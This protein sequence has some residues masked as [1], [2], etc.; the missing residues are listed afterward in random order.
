VL[1]IFERSCALSTSCHGNTASPTGSTGYRPYLGGAGD[2]PSDIPTIFEAII[3]YD[4]YADVSK[5]VVTPGSWEE[6]FL[7][8]AMDG[9]LDQCESTSC[10]DDCGL[11]MPR[12]LKNPLPIAERNLIRAWIDEGALDN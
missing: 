10:P 6:S 9:A 4:S 5:K 7:M 1:P 8:N 11:L 12:G 3:D 2:S